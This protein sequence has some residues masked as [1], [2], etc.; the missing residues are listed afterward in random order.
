MRTLAWEGDHLVLV[1]QTRLPHET[2]F[3]NCRTWREVGDAIRAMKVR[4]APA[5]GAAAAFG[6]VLAAGEIGAAERQAFL[7]RL[8]AAAAELR[9][10]RPTA[11]NLGWALDRLL[12]RAREH[13]G[14]PSALRTALLAEA[15]AI[16]AEDVEANRAIGRHGA[17]MI[18]PG[19]RILTYCNTGALA[20]VDYGT[21]FGILRTAHEEGKGIQV[22]ACETRPFL[23]GAR[24]T[25]WELLQH[26]IPAALITDNAAGYLMSRGMVDR[27]IVGADRIA[28]NGD[29][30]NKIGT[31]TLAI[32]A[33]HH[34]IPFVVAAPLSSVDF[35]LPD[36]SGIPIEERAAVEVT[37]VG[38]RRVAPGGMPV[39][40]P[41]FDITPAHLVTAIVTETG[42]AAPPF[43]QSLEA[44][45]A[46]HAARRGGR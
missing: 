20:T 8:E 7:A 18:G 3:V 42:V 27:V 21:A 24:L 41:A 4:G 23:Q 14:D 31:Y 32:L 25:S 39:L 11:V 35:A 22:L 46:V 9:G 34:E 17:Q 19:E 44:Q 28:A 2:A 15:E 16:A 10:A 1:D 38:G 29:V 6:L 5:I 43:L 36:G 26:G 12:R 45:R 40:N 13:A 37:H 33:R 30:A